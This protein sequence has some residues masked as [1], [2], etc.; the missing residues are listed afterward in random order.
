VGFYV[1]AFILLH[2]QDIRE[3]VIITI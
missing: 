2:V 1:T 3:T